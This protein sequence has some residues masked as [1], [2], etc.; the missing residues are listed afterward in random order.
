MSSGT[1]SIPAN[2]AFTVN[3]ATSLTYAGTRYEGVSEITLGDGT[4]KSLQAIID[5]NGGQTYQAGDLKPC[6][7]VEGYD[8]DEN[9]R[10]IWTAYS[11]NSLQVTKNET[12]SVPGGLWVEMFDFLGDKDTN[13]ILKM[14]HDYFTG[15]NINPTTQYDVGWVGFRINYGVAEARTYA[16]TQVNDFLEES[17]PCPPSEVGVPF[18]HY[19]RLFGK[20][21]PP[22]PVKTTNNWPHEIVPIR[23]LRL[24]RTNVTSAGSAI[25]QRVPIDPVSYQLPGYAYIPPTTGDW[26]P[27]TVP[28]Y[29]S[30]GYKVD[31][32]FEFRDTAENEALLEP[33]V[34]TD[35]SEPPYTEMKGLIAWRNG[36]MACFFGSRVMI[37]EP[38]R[39]FA[40]PRKY[41]FPLPDE[42]VALAIDG[43]ALVAITTV[44]PYLFTGSH[45]AN[46]N[47]EPLES[48]PP[49]LPTANTFYPYQKRPSRAVVGTPAGVIYGTPDGLWSIAGGRVQPLGRALFTAED[50]KLRYKAG[51]ATMR[52]AY[53]DGALLGYFPDTVDAQQQPLRGFKLNLTEPD[54]Q[55]VKWLPQITPGVNK[56]PS[57]DFES[58][59]NGRLNLI[60]RDPIGNGSSIREAFY[61][62]DDRVIA[63]YWTREIHLSKPENLGAFEIRGYGGLVQIDVFDDRSRVIPI[64]TKVFTLAPAPHGSVS[65]GRLPSG[66]KAR[67]YSVK[68][69]L[70][71][72]TVVRELYLASTPA[73]LERA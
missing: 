17:V 52:L 7:K 20:Y 43:N 28:P 47:Y 66:R 72:N 61:E 27:H 71:T 24:Y 15:I 31:Y 13:Y 46:V 3:N 73:E 16:M 10:Q 37:C 69:T 26:F 1:G 48:A 55:L 35:W 65:K 45:P 2:T 54:P 68:L 40:W 53:A 63:T 22:P 70:G 50:W 59:A 39:P 12:A 8:P 30:T 58:P 57:S 67:N 36:M 41:W 21:S 33:L 29:S 19:P 60:V 4:K 34:S 6:V 18:M 49:G 32:P 62:S 64:Y 9:N 51:F 25:Y 5:E 11:N 23:Y 14:W 38:F 42:I 44:Q 56:A